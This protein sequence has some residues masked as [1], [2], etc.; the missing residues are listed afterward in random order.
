MPGMHPYQ[1]QYAAP[2]APGAWQ[3]G[4]QAYP[5]MAYG[6]GMHHG[7]GYSQEGHM[8]WMPGMQGMPGP[9]AMSGMSVPM[10]VPVGMGM[11]V[12][13]AMRVPM[14]MHPAGYGMWGAG[15]PQGGTY[16]MH[17]SSEP[18]GQSRAGGPA[19]ST[20]TASTSGG[21]AQGGGGGGGGSG[22][23]R[24]S[25]GG[26]GDSAGAPHQARQAKA[27][28]TKDR[29]KRESGDEQRDASPGGADGDT[30][31]RADG[32]STAAVAGRA[33]NARERSASAPSVDGDASATGHGTAP[34]QPRKGTASGG[35]LGPVHEAHALMCDR[36]VK[37]ASV[38]AARAA[39]DA[40]FSLVSMVD[41][42]LQYVGP[43]AHWPSN[44]QS[45][46]I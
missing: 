18:G 28:P 27:E 30:R 4:M 7:H 29:T 23:L 2:G 14:G 34:S 26:S 39:V 31:K 6:G 17:R 9:G 21:L 36:L 15:T 10:G 42:E 20:S 19:P 35:T 45:A 24:R 3:Q 40:A 12:P 43:R 25:R 44:D 46:R 22:G 33:G 5:M 16:A 13:V 11:G 37:L 8:G 38:P 41:G 1:Q 32:S